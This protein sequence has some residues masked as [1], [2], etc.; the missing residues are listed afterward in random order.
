M[1]IITSINR[2][3]Q[4]KVVKAQIDENSTGNGEIGVCVVHEE[5]LPVWNPKLDIVDNT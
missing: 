3:G 4:S 5:H 1:L 2:V